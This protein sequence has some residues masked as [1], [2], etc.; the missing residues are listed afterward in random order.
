MDTIA[1]IRR[2]YKLQSLDEKDAAADAIAQFGNWWQDATSSDIDEVNAFVLATASKEGKPFARVVLLKGYDENGFVFFT[3]YQS[4][5][6]KELEENP[7]ASMVFFWK[8]LERQIRIEGFI[9]K[10]SAGESDAYF[11]SRPPGSRIGAWASP[12]SHVIQDRGLLEENVAKFSQ[13]FADGR[14]PR[15]AHWGGYCL[16]PQCIEFWQGRASRLHDRLQY[17]I[18]EDDKSWVI[19]RLAP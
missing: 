8:E 11:F 14:I 12:Q 19:E 15:P 2:E 4:N 1:D 7:Q 18:Q 5:K 10:I 6:G 16:K 3:N 13:Q 9:Q 17:T